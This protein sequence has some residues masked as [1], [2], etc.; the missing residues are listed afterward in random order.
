MIKSKQNQNSMV[1]KKKT[2]SFSHVE[3]THDLL[4]SKG[5][6]QPVSP[7]LSSAAHIA[8]LVGSALLLFPW[9]SCLQCPVVSIAVEAAPSLMPPHPSLSSG[10]LTLPLD[11]RPQLLSSMTLHAFKI[12]PRGDSYMLPSLAS[13]WRC[14]LAQS[15]LSTQVIWWSISQ[16]TSP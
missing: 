10:T 4:G 3:F 8:C 2:L 9:S 5:L 13:S 1:F 16:K 11:V 15:S 6:G 12:K 7:A 14:S